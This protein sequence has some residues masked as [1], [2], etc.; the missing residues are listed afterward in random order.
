VE[1]RA[2][3]N[4]AAQRNAALHGVGYRHPWVLVLDADE[5]VPPV[6]RA[7]LETF[8]AAAGPDV[9]AGRIRRRD[10][11]KGTWLRRSQLSPFYVRVVRPERVHYERAVNEVLKVDGKIADLETYFDHYPFSKGL[12]HWIAKHNVY[13]S[14]E[15][16]LVTKSR[17]GETPFSIKSAFLA[18]DFNERR[19][20]QKELFYRI[21]LRP[22]VKFLLIY[23]ARRGFLDGRAGLDY[24]LLQAMYEYLIVLKT[25]E[26]AAAEETADR[27]IEPQQNSQPVP[28]RA[29]DP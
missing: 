19:F 3:E 20:H 1:Q 5:R 6:L 17:R 18:R 12:A 8:V 26:L 21:P 24:A 14:M 15:A 10:Y 16:E 11:Y 27:P 7:E 13:S 25:R 4:F 28:A 22:V 23:I 29:P 9:V 2:F